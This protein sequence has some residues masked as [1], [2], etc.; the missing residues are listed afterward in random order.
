M[1]EIGTVAAGTGG[2]LLGALLLAC[3][4]VPADAATGGS[5]TVR[6]LDRHGRA[7]RTEVEIAAL[8]S[9]N[10]HRFTT[11]TNR[12]LKKGR[13]AISV[14]IETADDGPDGTQTL[15]ARTVTIGSRHVDV[16]LDARKGK[17]FSINPG[18]GSSMS[19]ASGAVCTAKA[20]LS[21]LPD[22]G[23]SYIVPNTDRALSFGYQAAWN[24]SS[25][26]TQYWVS[27]ETRGIPSGLVRDQAHLKFATIRAKVTTVKAKRQQAVLFMDHD[28]CSAGYPGLE[29]PAPR[30]LTVHVT[31][32]KWSGYVIS[33]RGSSNDLDGR[34]A[35]GKTYRVTFKA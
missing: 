27:G 22:Q 10:T 24:G 29:F 25:A 6:T 35:A 15:A 2:V 13:Y 34:F 1:R 17:R 16:I 12:T 18:R 9:E 20:L 31:P 33:P 3:Q 4:A 14:T 11:G 26:G 8:T 28:I 19:M 32:G 23:G 30:T 7:V 21:Q 5:L